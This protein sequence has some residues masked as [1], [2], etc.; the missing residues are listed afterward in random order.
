MRSSARVAA[1]EV[2]QDP[3]QAHAGSS[4]GASSTATRRLGRRS[5]TPAPARHRRCAGRP[6]RRA[7][8]R[9]AASSARTSARSTGVRIDRL[10]RALGLAHLGEHAGRE[11]RAPARRRRPPPR[12]PAP[13]SAT[14]AGAPS[15]RAPTTTPPRRRTA[16]TGANRRSSTSRASRSARRRGRGGLLVLDALAVRAALDQLD[17]VVAERPEERL[18]AL[19][20]AGVVVALEGVGGALHHVGER[21]EHRAVERL[22]DRR[23]GA[24]SGKPSTN[25][26]ALSSFTAR[27][28]PTFITPKST[29]VS[30]P[31]RPLQAQ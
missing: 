10:R 6:R 14:P 18:G 9:A 12:A 2:G 22:G 16:S 24:A 28:R 7:A 11:R 30:V 17:V 15:R 1:G 19:E 20:R 23:P 31:G 27:R 21:G 26:D 3:L 13:R 8:A 4:G 25:F 5:R 29:A